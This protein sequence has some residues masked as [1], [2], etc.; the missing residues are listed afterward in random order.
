V[1]S[2]EILPHGA[3][4]GIRFLRE[5][6]VQGFKPSERQGHIRS[7]GFFKNL[8]PKHIG[9]QKF[10]K[11]AIRFAKKTWLGLRPKSESWHVRCLQNGE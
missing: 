1:T 11:P 2:S 5:A 8:L 6:L 9:L 3:D 7:I 10:L 4:N